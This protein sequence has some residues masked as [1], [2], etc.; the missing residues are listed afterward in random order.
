MKILSCYIAGFGKFVNQSFDFSSDL[1]VIRQDNGWGKTTLADFIKSMFYGLDNGRSRSVLSNDRIKYEPWQGGAFGGALV[2]T[3]RDRTYRVERTFGRTPAQDTARVFDGNNMQCYD[4]GERA[5]RLGDVLFGVDSESY[6]KSVYVPQGNIETGDLPDTMKNRLLTLLSVGGESENGSSKAIEKLDAAERALRAKRRPAKGKL[7][8]I[9]E[10]LEWLNRQKLDCENYALAAGR[11][12][13]ELNRLDA[14]IAQCVKLLGE[15]GVAL[16]QA[17]RQG[18]WEARRETYQTIQSQVCSAQEELAS[19]REFF[20]SLDPVK[21][22]VEGLQTAVDEFY[23]LEAD[24]KDTEKK[25][26]ELGAQLQERESL[27]ARKATC[28]RAKQSYD[29]MLQE[30]TEGADTRRK[31]KSEQKGKSKKVVPHKGFGGSIAVFLALFSA[32]FGA[33]W[34]ENKPILGYILLGIGVLG[35]V[36]AFFTF[37]PKQYGEKAYKRKRRESEL[38][39]DFALGYS[40]TKA[41]LAEIETRLQALP[42]NIEEQRASLSSAYAEKKQRLSGLEGGIR[43]FLENFR[44]AEQYDYRVAV[45]VLKEKIGA[46][47]KVQKTLTEYG[48]KA[49]EFASCAPEFSTTQQRMGEDFSLLKERRAGIERRKDELLSERARLSSKLEEYKDRADTAAIEE[50]ESYLSSEKERLEKRLYAI[51]TAREILFRA[52]GNMASRYLDPVEKSCKRLLALFDGGENILHF[53]S[54]GI[55][56]YE[57]NGMTRSVDY[58]SVGMKEILGFCTRIALAETIFTKEKP[59]LILDDPFVNLDDTKTEKAKSL[60]RELSKTYQILYLT[61][62]TER[63]I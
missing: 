12:E 28:E 42:T 29:L 17:S 51:R 56:V 61:C 27:L 55:P 59:T 53:T 30:Q 36:I 16:E 20:G 4:F 41:E 48:S 38:D 60:V 54:D 25:I 32:I 5:E 9:D 3:F 52:R 31:E 14:E 11:A 45:S 1:I 57:N 24:L 49:N 50:E 6:K 58:Y 34:I 26:A 62:K 40:E 13:E 15:T 22:N 7:D 8:E 2:F 18:E 35:L 21:T 63:R 10:R 19:L 44:F 37:L 47:E 46:Y 23:A 43:N 39:S 33:I